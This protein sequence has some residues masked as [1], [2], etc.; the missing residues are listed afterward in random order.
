MQGFPSCPLPGER[1]GGLC[2]DV[3]LARKLVMAPR[4][5]GVAAIGTAP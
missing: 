1:G 3:S 2:V 4:S 5:L